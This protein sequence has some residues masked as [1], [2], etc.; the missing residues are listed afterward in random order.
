MEGEARRWCGG[1]LRRGNR[2]ETEWRRRGCRRQLVAPRLP[3]REE[4]GVERECELV[5]SFGVAEGLL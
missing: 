4:D 2:S 1:E 5:C 3:I